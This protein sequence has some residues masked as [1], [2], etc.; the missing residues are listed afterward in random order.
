MEFS[1]AEQQ[2]EEALPK[3]T[4][5]EDSQGEAIPA[6]KANYAQVGKRERETGNNTLIVSGDLSDMGKRE[7]TLVK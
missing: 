6:D 1:G 4:A 5:G 2:V 3:Q 7:R